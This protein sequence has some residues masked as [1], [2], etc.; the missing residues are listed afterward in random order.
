V[1]HTASP[2]QI[3][4]IEDPQ[5]QLIEPA[6]NGT[7][8][9]LRS[10]KKEGKTVKRVVLTSSIAAVEKPKKGPLK[11]ISYTEEDWN[12]ESL[13]EKDPYQLSKVLAEKAAWDF[14]E[15]D[16]HDHFELAVI[17]PSLVLG[18][19][20]SPRVD[21]VSVMTFLALLSGAFKETGAPPICTGIADVRDVAVAH[22]RAIEAPDAAGKRF[23]ISS[24]KQWSLLDIA[25]ALREDGEFANYPLPT[26]ERAPVARKYKY[27]TTAAKEI[28][29]MNF[30]DE[31]DTLVDM[32]R[33]LVKLRLLPKPKL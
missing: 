13:L 29:F 9:V 14:V 11:G 7:L 15:N 12:D 16:D 8:N 17:N 4:N 5:K 32:A 30:T 19:P 24:E 2:F 22:V 20:A 21:G 25:N 1:V 10:A 26:T 6:V 31:V 27:D 23:I 3:L 33:A 18:P 28:L